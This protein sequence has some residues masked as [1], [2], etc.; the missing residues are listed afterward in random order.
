MKRKW[1]VFLLLAA[2]VLTMIGCTKADELQGTWVL[3]HS[4][5]HEQADRYKQ[6][7]CTYA[8]TYTFDGYGNGSK[9]V[10]ENGY[11]TVTSFTYKFVEEKGHDGKSLYFSA[12][13]D[14]FPVSWTKTK[15]IF[16]EKGGWEQLGL[17]ENEGVCILIYDKSGEFEYSLTYL[18]TDGW[19][20]LV[21]ENEV[22]H[23]LTFK[24]L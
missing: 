12:I 20:W 6:E 9:A 18:K 15:I 23:K 14:A 2:I 17:S 24:R 5:V 21:I 7:E 4:W 10:F 19:E 1:I 22:I 13:S 3:E 8:V 11:T 16:F